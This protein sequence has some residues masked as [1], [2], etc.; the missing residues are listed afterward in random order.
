MALPT[1][2]G[3]GSPH[4]A[5]GG[6]ATSRYLALEVTAMP[7]CVSG[8]TAYQA[9]AARSGQP[10]LAYAQ[11]EEDSVVAHAPDNVLPPKQKAATMVA[12]LP[13]TAETVPPLIVRYCAQMLAVA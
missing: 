12:P 1:P 7:L 13:G 3:T 10:Q 5:K 2:L 9:R 11:P 4:D 6:G 8:A